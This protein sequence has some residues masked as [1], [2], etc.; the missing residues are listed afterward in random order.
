MPVEIRNM[1]HTI[2]AAFIILGFLASNEAVACS[3]AP[4]TKL[5]ADLV[6]E[7]LPKSDVAAVV[8]LMNERQDAYSGVVRFDARV[9]KVWKGAVA[10]GDV[11]AITAR[12]PQTSCDERIHARTRMVVFLERDGFGYQLNNRTGMPNFRTD[13]KQ[14]Y[15]ETLEALDRLTKTPR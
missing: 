6:P 5:D 9:E 15:A 1:K 8:F 7:V 11:I 10:P 13:W 2:C 3:F 14:E 12:E 4:G